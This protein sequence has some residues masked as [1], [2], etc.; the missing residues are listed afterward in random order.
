VGGSAAFRD[1]LLASAGRVGAPADARGRVEA[2]AHYGRAG[3][4]G[5]GVYQTYGEDEVHLKKKTPPRRRCKIIFPVYLHLC[6]FSEV[7]D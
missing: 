7:V 2:D 6:H 1:R 4:A 3:E 5:A